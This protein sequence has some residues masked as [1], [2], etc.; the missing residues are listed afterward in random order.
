MEIPPSPL[1]PESGQQFLESLCCTSP[2]GVCPHGPKP[3]TCHLVVCLPIWTSPLRVETQK[4]K[5]YYAEHLVLQYIEILL[6]A[7][8]LSL[9]LHIYKAPLKSFPIQA[10]SQLQIWHILSSWKDQFCFH[11]KR[12]M[13]NGRLSWQY[14]LRGEVSKC[15]LR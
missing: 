13:Q 8:E 14:Y 9:H 4:L 7:I 3:Q 11:L 2:L 1:F 15:I 6:S 12:N 5:W 10:Q